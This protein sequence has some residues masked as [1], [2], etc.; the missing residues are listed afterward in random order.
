MS[1]FLLGEKK[2]SQE[3]R[4]FKVSGSR[5][6]DCLV[7]IGDKD[8]GF[9]RNAVAGEHVDQAVASEGWDTRGADQV[10]WDEERRGRK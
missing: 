7:R 8:F 1:E 5:K 2:R 10:D 4:W 6:R 9:R 3:G